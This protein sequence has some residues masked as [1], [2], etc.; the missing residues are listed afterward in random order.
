MYAVVTGAS[1]GFG[2]EFARQLAARKYDLCIAARRE[3][4]LLALK[5]ELEK[6]YKV[7]VDVLPVDLSTDSGL[8]KLYKF[9]Q[10]KNVDIL[11]NNSGIATAGMPNLADLDKE[12]EML[13]IN[14]KAMHYLMRV[15]LKDMLAK[16]SG[17][18]LNVASLSAWGPIPGL[19]AY[20]AG[21]AYILH[22]S[23]GVGYELKAMKSDVSVS[24]VTPGFFNTGIAG[25]EANMTEQ[26]RSVPDFIAE[27]VEQFLNG[28]DIIVIGQD[29]KIP[30]L[31]KV[32]TR[33]GMKK[34]LFKSVEKA[35]VKK[36]K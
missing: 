30:F 3:S 17:S 8:K 12:M 29:K 14:V 32:L 6:K 28:K 21:K 2:I 19:S 11:I 27:V 35:L 23:E 25:K 20:A 9:T 36:K 24:V 5:K 4:N 15:Y 16:N 18:I 31:T 7:K 1:S 26:G 34:L 13:N 22:L 33:K 10:K